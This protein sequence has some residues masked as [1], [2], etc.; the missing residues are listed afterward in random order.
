[1]GFSLEAF[2]EELRRILGA[3]CKAAPRLRR[4][5]RAVDEAEKY[6]IQCG[7]LRRPYKK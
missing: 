2:I 4:I 5:Q 1:M 3:D 6:A 7:D